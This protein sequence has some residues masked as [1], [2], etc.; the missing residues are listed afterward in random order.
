MK[1]NKYKYKTKDLCEEL[2]VCRYTLILWEKKGYFTPP[3]IGTRGDRRFTQD[4]LD[5]IVKAFTPG[6]NKEWHFTP[7]N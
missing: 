2:G 3:R 7:K 1:V 6:G 5:G 4:Q